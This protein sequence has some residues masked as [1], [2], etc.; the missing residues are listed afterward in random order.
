MSKWISPKKKNGD[1]STFITLQKTQVKVDL[2][3]KDNFRHIESDRK[4]KTFLNLWA[5]EKSF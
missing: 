3:I 2:S 1:I 4:G 5:Q